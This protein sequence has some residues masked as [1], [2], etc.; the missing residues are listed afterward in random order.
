MLTFVLAVFLAAADAAHGAPSCKTDGF[1]I[2]RANTYDKTLFS[3]MGFKDG[4]RDIRECAHLCLDDHG[5]RCAWYSPTKT[6]E[7]RVDPCST[8]E[9]FVDGKAT[10]LKYGLVEVCHDKVA[11]V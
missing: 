11:L 1:K 2:V 10:D 6:C 8:S 5:C 3:I 7:W 4:V 9:L